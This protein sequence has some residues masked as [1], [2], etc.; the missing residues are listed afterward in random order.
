MAKSNPMRR[1]RCA[2]CSTIFYSRNPDHT[3]CD[4]CWNEGVRPKKAKT[5]TRKKP[6]TPTPA[7][8][9]ETP[10]GEVADASK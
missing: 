5:T 7:P 3:I 4:K 1:Q 6:A 8:E 10:S 2:N 9:P